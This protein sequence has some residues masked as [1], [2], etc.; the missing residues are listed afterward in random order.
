MQEEFVIGDKTGSTQLTQIY[1][2]VA[3]TVLLEMYADQIIQLSL[4]IH[5]L[6]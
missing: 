2:L 4:N 6:S 1:R 3:Q 5:Q